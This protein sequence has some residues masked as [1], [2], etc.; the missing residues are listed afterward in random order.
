MSALDLPAELCC[1]KIRLQDRANRCMH[2]RSGLLDSVM[3]HHGV[4]LISYYTVQA[5]LAAAY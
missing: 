4:T 3:K 2:V 5:T 1:A